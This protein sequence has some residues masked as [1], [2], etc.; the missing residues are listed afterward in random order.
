MTETEHEIVDYIDRSYDIEDI[1]TDCIEATNS[2][3][4][5]EALAEF[6]AARLI[7]ITR[8]KQIGYNLGDANE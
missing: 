2:D 1:L 8:M 4:A 3:V 5:I 7:F 6:R